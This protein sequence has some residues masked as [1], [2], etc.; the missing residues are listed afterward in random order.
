MEL[1]ILKCYKE[2]IS[3][4][5]PLGGQHWIAANKLPSFVVLFLF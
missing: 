4:T 1:L 2:K 3:S 5:S